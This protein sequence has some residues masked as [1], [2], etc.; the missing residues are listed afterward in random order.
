MM[1]QL[2]STLVI[3]ELTLAY[4]QHMTRLFPIASLDLRDYDPALRFGQK[5]AVGSVCI[6]LVLPAS[7]QNNDC[8][9]RH[10]YY[11]FFQPLDGEQYGWLLQVHQ[12]FCQQFS[13]ALEYNRVTHMATKDTLTELGNRNGFDEA[14]MRLIGR[15]QRHQQPFALLIMDLDNFKTVNDTRGHSEGDKVL[16]NVAQLI[17]QS[18]RHEDE[19]FRFGGDEFCCLMDCQTSDQL[20]AA[21]D[22]LQALVRDSAYL[23]N[24]AISCSLGGA[25]Y[26]EGDDFITLFDRADQA[27]YQAK[28][29]GKNTYQAA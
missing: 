8:E 29:A 14:L 4:Y 23:R 5:A 1:T 11:T 24:H 13:N 15:S 12:L 16:I 10:A 19:A 27:L 7:C 2:L 18:L 20:A 17:R 26:R 6:E 3:P 25:L 21:A 9:T 28:H 22:R